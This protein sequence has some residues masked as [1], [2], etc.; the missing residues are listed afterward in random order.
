VIFINCAK[1]GIVDESDL[2]DASNRAS[3]AAGVDV[4]EQESPQSSKLLELENVFA[5]PHIGTNTM[6][7][8]EAVSLIIAE[9]VYNALHGRPYQNAVNIPF[10]K[11]TLTERMRLYFDLAEKWE[12]LL[13]SSLRAA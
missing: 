2:Y 8:Q 9:Q 6:E 1:A 13:P 10:E 3:V 4:F 7:G 11:S 5:T 12:S